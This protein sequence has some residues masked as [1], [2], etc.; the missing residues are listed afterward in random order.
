MN[1]EQFWIEHL[2]NHYNE[3]FVSNIV[4]NAF[5]FSEYIFSDKSIIKIRNFFLVYDSNNLLIRPEERKFINVEKS[6]HSHSVETILPSFDYLETRVVEDENYR[7]KCECFR[8]KFLLRD[9]RLEKV[10]ESN[11][12]WNTINQ[13]NIKF[14]S[15]RLQRLTFRWLKEAIELKSNFLIIKV[16]PTE[17]NIYKLTSF[18]HSWQDINKI[19]KNKYILAIKNEDLKNVLKHFS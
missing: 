17:D 15:D 2:K 19:G 3:K 4:E 11:E 7:F 5:P 16:N 6:K 9:I 10:I 12:L 18:N 14:K 1:N 13:N 8:N